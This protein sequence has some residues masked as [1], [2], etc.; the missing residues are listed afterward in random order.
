MWPKLDET[1]DNIKFHGQVSLYISEIRI[2]LPTPTLFKCN[3]SKCQRKHATLDVGAG[4]SHLVE[5]GAVTV[6]GD[7]D[8]G[9]E[10]EDE[11]G[12]GRII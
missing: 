10:D 6:D 9:G 3:T 2:I 8:E 7:V 1:K 11:K 5:S 4:R 12:E